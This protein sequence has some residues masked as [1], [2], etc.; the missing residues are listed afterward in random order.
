[1]EPG[2]RRIGTPPIRELE[3]DRPLGSAF[4]VNGHLDRQGAAVEWQDAC[5][6]VHAQPD[7]RRYHQRLIDA[8]RPK[9][10][11]HGLD[12]L[13]NPDGKAV[14][15]ELSP[16]RQRP[17]RKRPLAILRLAQVVKWLLGVGPGEVGLCGLRVFRDVESEDRIRGSGG[18]LRAGEF[19]GLPWG[20]RLALKPGS[21]EGKSFKRSS[22]G[23]HMYAELFTGRHA[24]GCLVRRSAPGTAILHRV[25]FGGEGYKVD[26]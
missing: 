12:H 20:A 10:P 25:C 9:Y 18:L 11:V 23:M 15:G 6:G 4:R 17:G 7:G 2:L 19:G 26:T 21:R 22:R 8:P 24:P 1:M 5:L 16:R 3:I 14:K 13:A